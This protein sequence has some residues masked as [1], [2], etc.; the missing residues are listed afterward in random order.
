MTVRAFAEGADLD[1]ND[2]ASI[3]AAGTTLA[4]VH[5]CGEG[6]TAGRPTPSPW[7][8][9]FWPGTDD[10]PGLCDPE[11]DSWH[12]AFA[13]GTLASGLVH[14]DFYAE[15][16]VWADGRVAAVLDWSEAGLDLLAREL[17]WATWE[18]GHDDDYELDIDR[19]RTFLDGYREVREPQEPG[20]SDVLIAL[21][22][23]ELRRNARY[24]LVGDD[25]EYS[26]VLQ[27]AFR[28]LRRQSATSLLE[29]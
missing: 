28:R 23:V 18:F 26:T 4:L 9:S 29:P 1:R 24:A 20:L 3:R 13:G 22:R 10:P 25:P 27:R 15:N 7:H 14:G 6:M 2:A 19:A 21:M 17:A 5:R 16:I 11:L 12:H 8:S